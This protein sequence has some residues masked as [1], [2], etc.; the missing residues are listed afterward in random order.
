[1]K[2]NADTV[3]NWFLY[4]GPKVLGAIVV[5]TLAA[6]TIVATGGGAA[7]LW[8]IALGASVGG[9]VGYQATAEGMFQ[10][11]NQFDSDVTSGRMT[12]GDR[13]ALGAYIKGDV[14]Y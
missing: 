5:A 2:F 11:R 1:S 13:S 7:P 14:V 10:L 9:Y 12:Y 8:A 3:G 4:E 6:V